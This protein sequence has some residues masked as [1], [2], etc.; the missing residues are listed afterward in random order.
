MHRWRS[1]G[2]RSC[3]VLCMRIGSVSLK[4]MLQFR[5]PLLRSCCP[6][7]ARLAAAAGGHLRPAAAV[8]R[9]VTPRT[10]NAGAARWKTACAG[11]E[12]GGCWPHT[13]AIVLCSP[14]SALLPCLAAA[15]SGRSLVL[16]IETSCDDTGAAV[17]TT[18]GQVLGEAIA[19]QAEIHAAWGEQPM[20]HQHQHAA[21]SWHSMQWDRFGFQIGRCSHLQAAT[22]AVPCTMAAFSLPQCCHCWRRHTIITMS[23]CFCQLCAPPC[24]LPAALLSPATPRLLHSLVPRPCP[25][26]NALRSSGIDGGCDSLRGAI[27]GTWDPHSSQWH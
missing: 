4:A 12:G 25:R 7:S 23:Q 9:A 10:C 27:N 20:S 26:P 3:S 22:M 6:A 18:D 1:Q 19:H 17:V 24:A 8:C 21:C 2:V 5:R 14:A 16:G 15:V 11:E 13:A